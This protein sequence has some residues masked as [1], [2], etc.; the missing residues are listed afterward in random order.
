MRRVNLF[1][2]NWTFVKSAADAAAAAQTAGVML[3]LPHTW[4]SLDGQDGGNDY[5]RG[6]CWY[7]KRFPR[8]MMTEDQEV[9]LEFCGVAMIADVFLNGELLGH[10][11]GGYSAFRV[12]L[13]DALQEQNTLVVSADNSRNRTVYPQKADFTFY[14]GIYRDVNLITVPKAHFALGYH[15]GPAIKVTPAIEGNTAAV[16]VEAWTENAADGTTV[17]FA[18]DNVGEVQVRVQNDYAKGVLTIENVHLWDGLADPYLYTA[19]ATLLENGDQVKTQFGCRT[20]RVDPQEGFILNGR[21]YPL[22][23]AARHQDRLGV[24]NAISRDMQQ[25]DMA[26]MLEMGLNTI[27]LAHYQHDQFFYDLCDRHG[28]VAWVEIPYIT[29][30]MPEARQNT[31]SQMTELVVQ[32]CNHPSI[33]CWGLS[34]EITAAG[35]VNEDL[36]ENHRLLNDLCHRLDPTR[37][38]VMAHAF[39]LDPSH[40][41]VRLPDVSSYNLYFG[42]YVGDKT[43]NDRWFDDFHNKFPQEAMGL[44]EYGA[45]ANPQYQNSKPERGDTSESYQA[46]YHEHML[47][48]WQKRPYIWAMHCWNMFDF[49]A[50]G[51]NEGGKPGQ[52]QKGLVTFDRKLK[53]DAY[54]IYKAYLSKEPFVHICGRR[55]ADRCEDITEVKVYSNQKSISLSVDGRLYETKTG[56]LVFKFSVPI[57][58]L[59][60]ISARCGDLEDSI[61]IR[62]VSEPNPDY[63]SLDAEVINWFDK[64]EEMKRDGCYSVFDTILDLKQSPEAAQ[65]VAATMDKAHKSFGEVAEGITM[66]ESMQ[67]ILDATP[68]MNIIKQASRGFNEEIIQEINHAL[69]QIRKL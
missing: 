29:E 18:V 8:P 1:N 9:W 51:R 14:G 49:G 20:F 58:G 5:H 22:C 33:V 34:N 67:T 54:F 35:G 50:D 47:A 4:N 28:I 48:M 46:V 10:H 52:N 62:R 42:W 39:M 16:T 41:L 12:N 59:H 38:T 56:D 31:I 55:Y 15:G 7:V 37:F 6:T 32:S 30:H 68:L 27:R 3:D 57:T 69:N 36:I 61:E 65:V 13:T 21:R 60:Q 66:P 11:E 64:P 25:E 44:S 17:L 53:K 45:D 23:G 24:G 19:S 63:A 40:P 2:E 43:D 26:I